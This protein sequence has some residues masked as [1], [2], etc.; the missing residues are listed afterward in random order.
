MGK[1]EKPTGIITS[2]G[3]TG[4]KFFAGMMSNL[5]ADV[6]SI[7][8]PD[9]IHLSYKLG[10]TVTDLLSQINTVGVNNLIFNK[11]MGKWTLIDLS[12]RRFYGELTR[13]K[14][15]QLLYE[16]R[17]NFIE[18][19]SSKVYLESNVGY[20][21]LI[22]IVI[23]VFE[24]QRVAYIVRDGR[25]WVTS[26]MNWGEMFNKGFIRE[27]IGHSWPTAEYLKDDQYSH[28]WKSMD[29]FEQ[30]C[31]AW[32]SLNTYALDTLSSNP[33]SRI[34][35]FEEIFYSQNRYSHLE[36]FIDFLLNFPGQLPVQIN[37]ADG[38]LED[39]VHASSGT[40]PGWEDWGDERIQT[41]NNLC[42]SL[43][44]RLEYY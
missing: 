21:G 44:E 17:H 6:T 3:R 19:C 24:N 18:S 10:H 14:A 12:D 32:A 9:I 30:L 27:T 7:H 4:T 29:R 25:D 8:E 26:N 43:M 15:V 34:F 39:R 41:F 35:K 37:L 11:M 36:D 31:W 28:Q 13:E 16:Y 20:Y 5:S 38:V 2:L 1:I 42:G 23:D 33:F 40:F 22:D